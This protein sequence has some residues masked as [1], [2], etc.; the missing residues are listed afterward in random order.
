M[1]VSTFAGG[2]WNTSPRGNR[3]EPDEVSRVDSA[4]AIS[5]LR[6]KNPSD[7]SSGNRRAVAGAS[8]LRANFVMN[9]T[10]RGSP[11]RR[12]RSRERARAPAGLGL[13]QPAEHGEVLARPVAVVDAV[14]DAQVFGEQHVS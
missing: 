3:S 9:S 13:R 12:R 7:A 2:T 6:R 5:P 14:V 4:L 10:T 11:T 1:I 8:S